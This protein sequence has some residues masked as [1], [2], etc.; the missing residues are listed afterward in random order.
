[1]INDIGA[2]ADSFTGNFRFLGIDG[3]E[4]GLRGSGGGEAFDD[5]ED[6]GEFVGGGDGNGA[7]TGRFA[8][9]VDDFSALGDELVGVVES[10]VEFG[11]AAA[12]VEGVGRDVEDAHDDGR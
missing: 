3:E 9:D 6:A 2:S 11:V 5:G 4:R 8:A 12:V 10:S 7:G 1:V